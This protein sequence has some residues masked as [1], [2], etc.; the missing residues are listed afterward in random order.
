MAE[1]DEFDEFEESVPIFVPDTNVEFFNFPGLC[2]WNMSV[3]CSDKMA[4]YHC[5]WNPAIDRARREKF[6]EE[7]V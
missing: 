4:C 5:G 7:L 1:F 2:H 6:R 3:Q